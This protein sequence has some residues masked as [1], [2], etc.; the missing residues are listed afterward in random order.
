MSEQIQL[1]Y[2]GWAYSDF[3][4]IFLL[5]FPF[6]WKKLKSQIA[7]LPRTVNQPLLTF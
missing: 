1:D 7:E 5:E 3:W 4:A 2:S 6:T